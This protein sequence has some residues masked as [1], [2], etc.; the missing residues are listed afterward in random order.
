MTTLPAGVRKT[1]TCH[2]SEPRK[3]AGPGAA[4]G[5]RGGARAGPRTF[6]G[7]NVGSGNHQCVWR[8]RLTPAP[9]PREENGW[10]GWDT[11]SHQA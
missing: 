8:A 7:L 2:R 9:R 4:A 1:A 10:S 3:I 5:G 11:A 6:G